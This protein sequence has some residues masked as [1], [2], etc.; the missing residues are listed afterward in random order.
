IS[1]PKGII[2]GGEARKQRVGGEL[3]CK[4]Y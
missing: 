2:T 1:T 3:I 4:V